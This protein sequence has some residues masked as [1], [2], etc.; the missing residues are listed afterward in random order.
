MLHQIGVHHV[1]DHVVLVDP[2]HSL[3]A[4]WAVGGLHAPILEAG[5]TEGVETRHHGRAL[6][7]NVLTYSALQILLHFVIFLL[8][9]RGLCHLN[10]LGGRVVIRI[11]R[12]LSLSPGSLV[13][14]QKVGSYTNQQY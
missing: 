2:F 11:L 9:L 8:N 3:P 7:E 12:E 13:L 1:L 4:L 14:K 6:V 5:A 10:L